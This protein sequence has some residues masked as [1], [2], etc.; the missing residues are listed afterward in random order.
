MAKKAVD[1][2]N[3]GL[4]ELDLLVESLRKE[5]Y[6]LRSERLE[7]KNQKVHLISDK[8]LEIARALTVRSEKVR[9]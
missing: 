2:R 7:S 5:I 1:L 3:M 4:E 8:R 6:E 9:A